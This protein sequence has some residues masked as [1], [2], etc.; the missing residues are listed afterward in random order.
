MK[1]NVLLAAPFHG[2]GGI[3]R[4]TENILDYHRSQHDRVEID[5]LPMDRRPLATRYLRLVYGIWDYS[6]Y[7]WIEW[8][9]LAS[10]HYDVLH[11]CTSG[12]MG[13]TKDVVMLYLAKRYHVRTV[14]HFHFGR[15]PSVIN[16]SD[17]EGK[18]FRKA[19]KWV[20]VPIVIDRP[21]YNT[22]FSANYT[23]ARFIPNPLAAKVESFSM[24]HRLE[25]TRDERMILYA[26][27]CYA[28]KGIYELVR[29]CRDIDNIRLVL[30]G[31]IS[32]NL[33]SDLIEEAGRGE[34]LEILGELSHESV[35]SLMLQCGILVL[36]SYTEGF[37]NVILESMAC[38]C[39]I[40]ATSVGA[41]PEM[42]R[43]ADEDPPCGLL[44][45][46]K[47]EMSLRKAIIQFLSDYQL[48]DQCRKN[49]WSRVRSRYNMETVYNQL[50]EVWLAE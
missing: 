13:F 8:R 27:H 41:I 36:P 5:I 40:V 33:K 20:N 30:A 12:S 24:K 25:Y 1:K 46:S 50:L 37:P 18:C 42:L 32:E 43:E 22:L 19:M 2:S 28:S 15:L 31:T 4:W 29:V 34:W 14:L 44:V 11:L 9:M 48:R 45:P 10:H 47:D 21:S 17:W 3:T 7:I 38:G 16:A 35:L 39:A 26:G 49:A 23:K 6:K